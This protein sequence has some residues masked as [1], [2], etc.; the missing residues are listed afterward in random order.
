[1]ATIAAKFKNNFFGEVEIK[2]GR[3][4]LAVPVEN[5]PAKFIISVE[6]SLKVLEWE[7]GTQYKLSGLHDVEAEKEA[8]RFNDGKCDP[9]GRLFAGKYEKKK[10]V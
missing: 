3:V 7:S 8:N 4:T 10:H 2:E 5:E 9:K 1:M 6:R